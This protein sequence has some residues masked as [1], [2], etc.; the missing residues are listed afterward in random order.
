MLPSDIIATARDIY[1]ATG[2]NF[3]T[4]TQMYNWIWAAEHEFAKKAWLIERTFTTPTVSGTQTYTYPTNTIAIKRITVNGKKIKRITHR[5]DDAITLSNA[6][7]TTQGWPIYYTDFNYTI[8]LRPIP[9]GVYTMQVFTYQDASQITSASQVLETPALFHMD[10]VDYMLFRMFAK[11]RDAQNMSFH[12]DEWKRH[13]ADAVA[14]KN[15]MKRTDSFA[16]VQSEDVL[17]VNIVGEN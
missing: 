10:I 16:T 11:D 12:R 5:Y 8:Y 4:D 7:V 15:R 2:D 17:P 13:V 14:Y 9:D 3:F 1:N 6:T